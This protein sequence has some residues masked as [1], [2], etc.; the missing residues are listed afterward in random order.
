M[1][2]LLEL[3]YDV[4]LT[5]D[6]NFRSQILVLQLEFFTLH[7]HWKYTACVEETQ[8]KMSTI[9]IHTFLETHIPVRVDLK[10]TVS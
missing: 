1:Y 3:K 6:G 5:V 4:K 2:W 7:Y 10:F 8:Q 9:P